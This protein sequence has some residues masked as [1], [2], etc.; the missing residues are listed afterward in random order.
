MKSSA[1]SAL[2]KAVLPEGFEQ[3]NE[4][5]LEAPETDEIIAAAETMPFMADRRLV[6][7]RDLPALVG[8]SEG[9]E[10]LQS[11]LPG[12]PDT[13]I[14]VFYCR[15]KPD[16]RKKLYSLIKKTGNVVV[17]SPLKDL[18][19]S[20]WVVKGFADRGRE[21]AARTADFL[22]FTCGTDMSLLSNEI[23]KI[24]SHGEA[25]TPVLPG[26]ISALATPS[27]ECTVF[28][29]VDAV[30][31]GQSGRALMLM[32]NLLSAGEDRIGLLAMLLRQYR[33]LQHVKIMQYEKKP[34]EFIQQ[35]LGLSPY[36]CDRYLQQAKQYTGGQVKRAVRICADTDFAIKSGRIEQEGSLEKVMLTLLTLRNK[37]DE[38]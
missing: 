5:V 24:A 4:T 21:C 36:V 17:F 6:I 15:T 18:E 3:L 2:R 27:T 25:G 23:D 13:C 10:Q 32:R 1:L 14:L 33:F 7:V 8:K 29:M 26:E 19:L 37:P 22:I 30:I 16:A 9:D 31:S 20:S 12:L 28:Q 35:A 34:R 11:Y 38:P